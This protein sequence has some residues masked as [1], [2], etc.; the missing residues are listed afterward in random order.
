MVLHLILNLIIHC[1]LAIAGHHCWVKYIV[2]PTFINDL[3]KAVTCT[4][5]DQ[6]IA[7]IRQQT[8][9]RKQ[10]KTLSEDKSNRNKR[11][12]FNATEK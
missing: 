8:T 1:S 6:F 7:Q 10:I 5:S 12:S 3:Q 2:I 11:N 4:L 9:E